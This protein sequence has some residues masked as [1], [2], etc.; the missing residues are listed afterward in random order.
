MNCLRL[1]LSTGTTRFLSPPHHQR[2]PRWQ[3]EQQTGSAFHSGGVVGN[4]GV[5]VP[6][7]VVLRVVSVEDDPIIARGALDGVVGIGL[8][9]MEVK[10]NQTVAALEG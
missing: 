9:G 5:D 8:F 6:E 4:L 10:D 2:S 7:T 1:S 3:V